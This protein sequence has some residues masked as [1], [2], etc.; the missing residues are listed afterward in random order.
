MI[1]QNLG[2]EIIT[3]NLNSEI[4]TK[5]LNLK[6]AIESPSHD[7]DLDLAIDLINRKIILDTDQNL[8]LI[9]RTDREFVSDGDLDFALD[10]A[11]TNIDS[12]RILETDTLK[13]SV[14]IE[15]LNLIIVSR[16]SALSP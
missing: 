2:S 6:I 9:N 7:L 1:D 16:I 8:N 11:M 14:I 4:I 15:N 10:S 12:D 5:N 3:K 13:K